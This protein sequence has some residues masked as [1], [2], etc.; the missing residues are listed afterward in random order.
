MEIFII[1]ASIA[2]MLLLWLN[3]IAYIAVKHDQT[4]NS[5]QKKS[6]IIIVLLLPYIGASLVL[7]MVFDHSPEAIPKKLIPWP[8][9]KIIYGKPPRPNKNSGNESG[10]VNDSHGDYNSGGSDAGGGG[11]E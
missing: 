10:H 2:F 9:K 6:Q 11:G 4:L 1:L 8:F 5:F 7:H 3:F